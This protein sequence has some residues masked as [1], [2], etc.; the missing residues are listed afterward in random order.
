[1]KEMTYEQA[2]AKLEEYT[3]QLESGELTLDESLQ[4]FEKA[5]ALIRYCGE[6]LDGAKKQ[7]QVLVEGLNGEMTEKPFNPEDYRG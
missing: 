3:E 1:M 4:V 7:M 6:K 5:V 2:Y